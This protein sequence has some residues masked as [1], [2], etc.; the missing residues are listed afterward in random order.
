M[1]VKAYKEIC[2]RCFARCSD[3]KFIFSFFLVSFHRLYIMDLTILPVKCIPG[4]GVKVFF[5][6]LL[7]IFGT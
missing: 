5:P 1:F 7:G 2:R 6:A 4:V 3:T